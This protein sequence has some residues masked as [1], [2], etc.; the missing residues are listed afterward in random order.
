MVV[1]GYSTSYYSIINYVF[2]VSVLAPTLSILNIDELLPSASVNSFSIHSNA[3][4]N[5][6]H[7]NF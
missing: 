7:V 6:S 4:N 2:Q 3:D 1:K 5:S